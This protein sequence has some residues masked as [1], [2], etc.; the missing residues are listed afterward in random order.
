MAI[1][2]CTGNREA[3]EIIRMLP[4][5]TDLPDNHPEISLTMREIP[6]SSPEKK[7]TPSMANDSYDENPRS[8][9]PHLSKVFFE[10]A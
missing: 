3:G 10:R 6:P 4:D 7:Q 8:E 1:H 9:N 2:C 5:G